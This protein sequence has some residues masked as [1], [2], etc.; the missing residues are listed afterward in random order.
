M[1]NPLENALAFGA[2]GIEPRWTSSAKEGVGTAYHTSCRLWFTLSHGIINEIYYPRV[3]RPN[4]R[5]FQFLISDGETF[6]HEEKRDLNHVV[7]YPERDCLL[8]RLTNSEPSGRYR[9][10]KHVLTDPHRS[11]LLVHTKVEV[12]DE[13]LRGKLRLYALVA[14]HGAGN[15][16]RCSEIRASKPIPG[17]GEDVPLVV[18]CSSEFARRSVGYVGASDGWQDLMTNF[19]MDWEFRTAEGGNI[20]LTGEIDL[21]GDGEFTIAIACGGSYQSTA[22]KLLQSLAEPV[23]SHREGYV[24]Q[25]QRAVVN[26]RF[27]FSGD[28]SDGGGMYRLSRCVLLAHED[29]LFQGALV[30][31]MSIPWG[32]T[33]DDKDLGGYH[34]VW[35]RDLV[36]SATALLATGQTGTPLRALIWLA[37]I[38]L[39]DG[40]FP[41][42]SWI[43]GEA[44]WCGVQLDEVGAPIL[45]AWRLH[46]EG[47]TL[48]RFDP[49]VMIFRAA[50]F[51]IRH[52]PVTAQDRW[53]ESAGYSPST[54]ATVI[55]GLVCAA[56]FAKKCHETDTSNF[57]L[58]YADWLAAH[59]EEWTVT[60]CGESVEGFRRHYIRINPT[61]LQTPDPH[62]DPNTAMLGVANG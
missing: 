33:K 61:D 50:A 26:P 25:W 43:N 39:P 47:V 30:A 1:M 8:Y 59:V 51:L 22:A 41:Q 18:A 52:G 23:E 10:V 46:C 62:A 34:L 57:I 40:R 31:S 20:A 49:S 54:L 32:E 27:D 24:R 45:L 53:E 12:L 55:A 29:K 19:K 48:G 6:C 13:S 5:D 60:T 2:P 15:S 17:Q 44:Y 3:D 4:T 58:E 21:P 14:P 36:Q 35:T 28:T 16:A 38:Q 37:A 56:E 7:E 42:N 9:L 11:V